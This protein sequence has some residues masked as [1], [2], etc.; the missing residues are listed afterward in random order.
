MSTELPSGWAKTTLSDSVKIVMGQSPPSSTYNK[1]GDGLPFF[2]GKSEFG[3]VYPTA[4]KFCKDPKKIANPGDILISVRA[5]VGPTNICRETSCIG[6]GLAS[7]EAECGISSKYLFFFMR[8]IEPWLSKEGTG[9]TFNAISR[10][11]LDEL[12]FLIAPTSEQHRIVAKLE[13]LL[14]KVDNCKE[15]LEKIPIILKRFRQSVLAAACSGVLTADWRN[16]VMKQYN[17]SEFIRRIEYKRNEIGLKNEKLVF[18]SIS[19]IPSTWIAARLSFFVESMANGIYKPSEFYSDNAIGCLRMYNIQNG[20]I[21]WG[22]LKRMILTESEL[23]KF[24]LH[25]GDILVNRVNSRELVGKSAIIGNIAEPIVFES[26]NIRLRLVEK[27]IM[28]IFVNYCFMLRLVRDSFEKSAKQTVGMA[29]ISQPQISAL[30]IP[31]PPIEEQ[32]E[33]I[34]RVEKLFK[35]ADEIEAR[36]QKA[37]THVTRLTQSILAKAFRGELVPQDPNDEPASEL[38]KRIKA[39]REQEQKGRKASSRKAKRV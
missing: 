9:S 22:N 26:K 17:V 8:N 36:Y 24:S 11:N 25:T 1:R 18:G 33:I 20:G 10:R 14:A 32:K 19:D 39:E 7:L 5:P 34:S 2:Q 13:K 37:K 6:R 15:R 30:I 27:E 16:K 23:S 29:T 38:L 35:L 28:P 31:I 4:T 21:V 12:V 3:D